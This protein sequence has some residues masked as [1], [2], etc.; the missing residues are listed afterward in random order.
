MAPNKRV[1]MGISVRWGDV[2]RSTIAFQR[3]DITGLRNGDYFIN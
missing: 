3:I 2:Y 1:A